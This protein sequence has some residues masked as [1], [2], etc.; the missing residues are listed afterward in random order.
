MT[1]SERA[2]R[3]PHVPREEQKTMK[4]K[5]TCSQNAKRSR[6]AK[7]F[8]NSIYFENKDKE[9]SKIMEKSQKMRKRGRKYERKE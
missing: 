6:A 5:E 3:T 8:F 1:A 2:E 4:D 7:I 9:V